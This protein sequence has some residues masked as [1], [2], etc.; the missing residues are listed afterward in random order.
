MLSIRRIFFALCLVGA[1]ASS[2]SVGRAETTINVPADFATITEAIEA[3]EWGDTILVGPGVYKES[4]VLTDAKG[5]GLILKSV[6]GP[7]TTSIAYGE[8]AT[9]NEAVVTFQRCSNSTQLIGFTI[10]GRGVAKRG[11]LANSNSVPVLHDLVIDG[12]DYGIACHRNSQPYI[13]ETTI[14][15]TGIAGLFVQGGSADVKDC[16]FVQGEKFGVYIRGTSDPVK[17]RDIKVTENAQV[18][19]QA[20]EGEFEVIGADVLNNGDTGLILQDVSPLIRNVN[21][22][23]HANIGI[24]IEASSAQIINSTIA[25]NQFGIIASIEG[26]PRIVGCKFDANEA[27]HIGIEGDCNPLIGGSESQANEFLGEPD[28][29]VQSS[30][31]AVVV[32]THNYWG[33]PCVPK[34]IFRVT[35]DGRLKRKPWMSGNLQRAFEDCDAARKYNKKWVDGKLDEAGN[36]IGGKS[37]AKAKPAEEAT[38][39]TASAESGEG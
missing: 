38:T 4:I 2:G 19:I 23:G 33:K 9:V 6:E 28:Y 30:S 37:A 15:K 13:R 22:D 26:E 24:V 8:A 12:A 1:A 25:N 18:G 35:G 14:Q 39:Q 17:L 34:Q 36:P 16:R 11:I 27:Y 3:S 21:V 7:A 20:M 31:S 32:A 10:D 29:V 5:D